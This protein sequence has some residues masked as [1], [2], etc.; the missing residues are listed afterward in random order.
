MMGA[1]NR[2]GVLSNRGDDPA[3]LDAVLGRIFDAH[4]LRIRGAVA[5]FV[6]HVGL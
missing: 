5:L 1:S 3:D 6:G 4:E 2:R